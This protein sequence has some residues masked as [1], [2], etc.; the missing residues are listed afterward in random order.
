[1]STH[2]YRLRSVG[3]KRLALGWAVLLL[4]VCVGVSIFYVLRIQNQY[5]QT[6]ASA[7][8]LRDRFDDNQDG[9]NVGLD[10]LPEINSEL[11]TLQGDLE[12]LKDQTDVPFL[13]SVARN[14]PFISDDVRATEDLLD[15]GLELTDLAVIGSRIA[16]D[17]RDA[18]EANGL[19]GSEEV[20]GD[21]WLDVVRDNRA[22]I[23]DL[24][25]RY[26]LAIVQR[27]ELDV[28]AL[29]GRGRSMLAS[30]DQ[31]MEKSTKFR[32]EYFDL[33]PVLDTAFGAEEDARYYLMLQNSQELRPSG[34]FTGTYAIVTISNGRL[35]S[36]DIENIRDFDQTYF[37][38]VYPL[39]PTP[40]PIREFLKAEDWL[41]RDANWAV[42]F[43]TSSEK[44]LE[45]WDAIDWPDLQGIAAINDSVIRDVFDIIGPFDVE[46]EGELQTVTPDYFLDLIQQY[47]F[48]ET[49]EHKKVVKQLGEAL[50]D[51]IRVVDF[52]TKKEIFYSLRDA[53]DRRE[54]QAYMVEPRLEQEVI[55]RGW[56]GSLLNADGLPTLAMTISNLTGNK[57]SKQIDPA[58]DL[59]LSPPDEHEMRRITMNITFTHQ[60]EIGDV[61]TFS[62][63]HRTW[64]AIYLPEDAEL[65]STS[66][67]PES[68]KVTD[69]PLAI[70]FDVEVYP[71]EQV[72]L[73][74]VF[75]IPASMETLR[76]RR[77]SGANDTAYSIEGET[78]TC[79]MDR[80]FI[81]QQDANVYFDSC[82]TEY[83]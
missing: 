68:A 46:I 77:Q 6:K 4:L 57:S 79:S 20:T 48:T 55:K 45:M 31:L 60:G 47:R 24:E 5:E 69:D 22:E 65:I 52:D 11:E 37:D 40:G 80:T 58:I 53:A 82:V 43:P 14:T 62:A 2:L 72:S 41:P 9:G 23:E 73:E 67:Q 50:I 8:V 19:A 38:T 27:E 49:E 81:L 36:V 30:L 13:S 21:T 59:T 78:G 61:D 7:N 64:T 29:P 54:V 3:W 51:Q 35:A 76:L 12:K 71:G 17:A 16:N 34:G 1:M 33:L 18:F 63:F 26:S 10:D 83:V 39:Q 74:V 66:L 28:D 25:T 42:D 32:D 70:G 56:D 44:T 15:L 75:E